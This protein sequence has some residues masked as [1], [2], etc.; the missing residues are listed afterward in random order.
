L[1]LD[2]EDGHNVKKEELGAF[3]YR[4]QKFID[5][6]DLSDPHPVEVLFKG[7]AGTSPGECLRIII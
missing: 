3:V 2:V 6:V 5:M 4:N 1:V 7:E